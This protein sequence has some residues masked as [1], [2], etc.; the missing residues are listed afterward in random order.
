MNLALSLPWQIPYWPDALSQAGGHIKGPPPSGAPLHGLADARL[1]WETTGY[2]PSVVSTMMDAWAP[3]TQKCYFPKWEAF[4][5][6]CRE[7]ALDPF[8][9]PLPKVLEYLQQLRS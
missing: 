6:W 3:S 1:R 8:S 9:C 4:K 2:S 7:K 5:G